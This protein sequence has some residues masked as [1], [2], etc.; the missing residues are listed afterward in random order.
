MPPAECPSAVPPAGPAIH[1]TAPDWRRRRRDGHDCWVLAAAAAVPDT[2]VD[3]VRKGRSNDGRVRFGHPSGT[4]SV[5]AQAE[6]RGGVW[7]VTC[8]TMS[9]SARRLME[10]AICVPAGITEA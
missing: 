5:G 1:G 8:V 6:Q 9:R 4:L 2:I 10:G 3:R 7:S